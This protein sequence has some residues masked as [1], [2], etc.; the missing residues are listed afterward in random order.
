VDIPNLKASF[1][2]YY[3]QRYF[4]PWRD[5]WVA[6]IESV[7]RAQARLP[8]FFNRLSQSGVIRFIFKKCFKLVDLPKVSL[9]STKK[10]LKLRKAPRFSI[11]RLTTLSAEEKTKSV[12]LLQDAFTSFYHPELVLK[13]Y[14][15]FNKL[16]FSTYVA[17]FF[18][19]G[20]PYHTQGFLNKF[21]RIV[22]RNI[23]FL[24]KLA[25]LDI[26]IIGLDP[27]I[28]LTYRDEYHKI[29]GM[30][31]DFSVLLPQEWL[32]KQPLPVQLLHNNKKYFLLS[33]CTEKTMSVASE[34]Q[35]CDIFTK[36][37]LNLQPL[38]VGCCG[39]SGSYGHEVE[40]V[41]LSNELFKMD[42]QPHLQMS[43]E[44]TV[45]L[46]TGY[47]CRSQINRFL[48]KQIQH[49]LEVLSDIIN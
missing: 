22:K 31:R 40:H 3:Y 5:Y 33:H 48:N 2:A 6:S 30:P 18:I 49:P 27:S 20:K 39:M 38:S 23:K 11:E 10:E 8:G 12:I 36:L 17:P 1:L 4:R 15:L 41:G 29:Q 7:A 28:T 26:P 14:D 43:D 34:K 44:N 32:Q 35:W 19:N 42:W 25:Q 45:F 24:N 21:N 13:T 37:G 16:G 47:S 46:A 9:I